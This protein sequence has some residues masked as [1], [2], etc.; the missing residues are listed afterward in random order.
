MATTGF[1][2]VHGRLKE[3]LDYA[4]NPDKAT[5]QEFLDEDLYAAIRYVESDTKTDRTMYVSGINCSKHNAYHEM[6]AVKQ[7]FGERGTNIAYHGYQSFREGEVTPEEAHQIG[8]ETARQMW[9]GRYQVVVTTHL[10][11]ENL[12]N[13]FIVNSVSFVDGRKFRNSI[14]DRLELRKISDAICAERGK[15]VIEGHKFYG[16]KKQYWAEKDRNL[17]HREQLRRDIE[18]ILP[19]CRDL[20]DFA[21]Q[22]KALGY[23]FPRGEGNAHISII[24]AGWQRAVRLDSVG[25]GRE[26][27]LSRMQQQKQSDEF[28]YNFRRYQ[29]YKPK[30]YPLLEF[31]KQLEWRI[32]HT[33]DGFA[34]LLD[35]MFYI[36]IALLRLALDDR[37]YEQRSQPLSPELRAEARK[38]GEYS[39]QNQLLGKYGIHAAQEL[40]AFREERNKQLEE[41]AAQRQKIYNKARRASPEEKERLNAEAR[42][43]S[44]QMKPLQE[45]RD[46]A[47]RI[48]NRS[49]PRIQ[50]LLELERNT[51]METQ[52][53]MK[54]RN[55][56]R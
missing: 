19:G 23:S 32:D 4:E 44:A 14:G 41:L 47:D 30:R 40:I 54:V 18:K 38:M 36:F 2:P 49:V 31:E 22:M 17:S 10:N 28:W 46:R 21:Y 52:R 42:A 50:E 37:G 53:K 25:H 3:V 51:E 8:V 34:V 6:M 16:N 27:L 9:G 15:S 1:W 24:A 11:T 33:R 13:H 5:P 43:I 48:Y 56:E 39:K 20:R 29:P 45:E 7:R 26:A 12:H 55:Y 35:T